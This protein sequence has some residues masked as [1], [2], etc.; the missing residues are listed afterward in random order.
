VTPAKRGKGNK[1]RAADE[2][3]TPAQR[4]AAMTWVQRLKRV[5]NIR[6]Q[7][8]SECGGAVKVI[9]CIE[10]SQVIKKILDH[11]REKAGT[12]ETIALPEGRAPP[13][14]LFD[15]GNC[16]V[17]PQR[18]RV[19]QMVRMKRQLEKYRVTC[20]VMG[21]DFRVNSK[22]SGGERAGR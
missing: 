19:C 21:V 13:M 6:I 5:F 18:G 7:T 10:D 20:Q 3:Q 1:T 14:G 17:S 16:A 2:S 9:A 11:L 4:R 15:S 8:C 22:R 12:K